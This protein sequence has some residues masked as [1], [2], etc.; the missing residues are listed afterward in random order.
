MATVYLVLGTIIL[1]SIGAASFTVVDQS[2]S[3]G[4]C[5]GTTE[6]SKRIHDEDCVSLLSIST[7][8]VFKNVASA[9]N[10]AGEMH[11]PECR[12][13]L[14]PNHKKRQSCIYHE[15]EGIWVKKTKYM[16]ID[17]T[18]PYEGDGAKMTIQMVETGGNGGCTNLVEAVIKAVEAKFKEEIGEVKLWFDAHPARKGCFCYTHAMERLGFKTLVQKFP[19]DD[20]DAMVK[21]ARAADAKILPFKVDCATFADGPMEKDKEWNAEWWFTK[22]EEQVEVEHRK[23]DLD[24]ME[25]RMK[26]IFDLP[27]PPEKQTD[28][29]KD[30]PEVDHLKDLEERLKALKDDLPKELTKEVAKQQVAPEAPKEKSAHPKKDKE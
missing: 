26:A 13:M 9:K 20:F 25:K 11:E 28:D 27:D 23:E 12:D 16:E 5:D 3:A 2:S 17:Y 19:G 4:E 22:E 15:P 6:R 18:P 7:K 30:V 10:T 24:D 14:A 21:Y 8:V 1:A 29:K